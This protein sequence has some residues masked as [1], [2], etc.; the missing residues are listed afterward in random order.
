MLDM[1]NND[2]DAFAIP[3]IHLQKNRTYAKHHL[4]F[5]LLLSNPPS[6]QR[7]TL[8]MQS[9]GLNKAP[10]SNYTNDNTKHID[11]VISIS[12]NTAST[13]SIDAD[14]AV[15]FKGAGERFSD[16]VAF[17]V[18]RG[19]GGRCACCGG[20]HVDEFE[21]KEAGECSAEVADTGGE[22]C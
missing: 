1:N 5:P 20:E 15:I 3:Q 9:L 4:S 14:M 21:D 22:G 8:Q 11:N 6:P 12:S 19:D 7:Q 10:E 16:Q 13:A 18:R 17:E 2:D